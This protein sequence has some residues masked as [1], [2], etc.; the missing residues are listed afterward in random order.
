MKILFVCLGNICRSPLA[1]GIMLH[2]VKEQ[3]LSIII[4]SAGT[5]SWHSGEPPDRRAIE[6]AAF[7][8]VDIS[9]LVARP[10]H[11]KDFERFDKIFVMDEMNFRDVIVHARSE[12]EKRKVQLF[13]E[14]AGGYFFNSVPDPYY[15]G[16][17]GFE[18]VFLMLEEGCQKILNQINRP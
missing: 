16:P 12:D 18:K 10:F 11:P 14:A 17:A 9:K 7:H 1:E 8:G 15:G 2:K 13:L 4:D 6:T 3:N 5:S